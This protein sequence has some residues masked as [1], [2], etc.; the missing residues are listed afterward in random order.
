[1]RAL[2]LASRLLRALRNGTA[3]IFADGA[4][5]RGETAFVNGRKHIGLH[6]AAPELV[7][8]LFSRVFA[9][10]APIPFSPRNRCSTR[11]VDGPPATQP[12]PQRDLRRQSPLSFEIMAKVKTAYRCTE[13]G[14][15]HSKWQG[16]C[17]TCGEW[18]TLVEEIVTPRVA[19]G[20][21]SARRAAGARGLAEGGS[22]AVAPRLR[23][24]VGSHADRWQT[25]LDEFD[26][27][28][29]GGIVPGSMILVG[30]EP[31][32]GKSTLLLQVAARLEATGRAVLYASGEESALQVQLRADRLGGNAGEVSLLSETNLETILATGVG[33][34]AVGADRRL[35]ADRVHDGSR[36]RAGERR[37]GARVRGAAH[38][39]R[40]GKRNDGVRR[41]PRD[42]RR[43]HRRTRR[44]SSTSSTPCCISRARARSTTACCARRRTDSAAS[45]RSASSA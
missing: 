7:A 26:F 40:E 37:T 24:V 3:P 36:R 13:C 20:A 44:R 28:L 41:R 45:T 30:G 31:G 23:D 2:G 6:R 15:E 12:S 38:A 34:A 39:F 14:A 25:G 10:S 1:M 11:L 22:V 21:M 33:I 9:V 18:N 29:G 43:R 27:V 5:F 19:A 42:Q 17:D 4:D 16:R 32:I 8:L 35:D